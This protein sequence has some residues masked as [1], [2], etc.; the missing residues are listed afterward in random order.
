MGKLLNFVEIGSTLENTI[1]L[2]F[3]STFWRLF[4]DAER[5]KIVTMFAILERL[6]I[7]LTNSALGP[8]NTG[9][10]ENG[11]KNQFTKTKKKVFMIT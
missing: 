1:I 5:N 6:V 11:A 7:K 4:F 3:L 2:Q 9:I 8:E 10:F